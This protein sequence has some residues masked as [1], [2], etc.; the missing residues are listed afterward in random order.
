LSVPIYFDH[1]APRPVALG[2]RARDVDVV[3]A[4]QDGASRMVDEQLLERA[5]ALGR[6]LFSQDKD[7]LRITRRWLQTGR[8]FAGLAYAPQTF[9]DY[10]RLLNDLELIAKVHELDEVRNQIFYLPL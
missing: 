8:D 2:L 9:R 10:G 7:L 3:T 4:L 1:N 5:T 6:L